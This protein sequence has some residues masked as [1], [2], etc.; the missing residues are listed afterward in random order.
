ARDAK[1]RFQSTAEVIHAI[2]A[3]AASGTSVALP[4]VSQASVATHL[5]SGAR[6]SMASMSEANLPAGGQK[7]A[8]TWATSQPGASTI[9]PKKSAAPAI[10]AALG[11][12]VLVLGGGAYAAYA[13]H[14]KS[15]PAASSAAAIGSV[16][17]PVPTAMQP[18][19]PALPAPPDTHAAASATSAPP[20]PAVQASASGSSAAKIASARPAV[21]TAAARVAKPAAKPAEKPAHPP[22]AKTGTPDFGY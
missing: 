7:T 14:N 6:A 1:Q 5:P 12:G 2:D 9:V 3:W 11:V 15:L 18:T 13:L 16:S 21:Q 22:L 10:A 19:L 8:G 4:D 20:A 17:P